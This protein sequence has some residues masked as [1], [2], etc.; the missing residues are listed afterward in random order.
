M[1]YKMADCGPWAN[2][3]GEFC[4]NCYNFPDDRPL[5][6][7][8]RAGRPRPCG[9]GTTAKMEADNYIGLYLLADEPMPEGA[10]EVPTPEK[11]TEPEGK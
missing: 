7:N 3:A 2:R 6:R 4:G 8:T 11:L 9:A 10:T 5:P 1:A